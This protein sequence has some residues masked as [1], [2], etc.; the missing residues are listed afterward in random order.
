[1]GGLGTYLGEGSVYS[2]AQAGT[3]LRNFGKKRCQ[4]GLLQPV[5]TNA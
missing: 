2:E 5:E 4:A 1:M 3:V